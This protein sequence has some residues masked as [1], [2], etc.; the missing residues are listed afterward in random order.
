[1]NKTGLEQTNNDLGWNVGIL[2]R[3]PGKYM[4][5]YRIK[6][7]DGQEANGS[8]EKEVQENPPQTK[9]DSITGM[10][11]EKE[12]AN[13]TSAESNSLKK[14]SRKKECVSERKRLKSTSKKR[15]QQRRGISSSCTEIVRDHH[16][17]NKR[18]RADKL[19]FFTSL[20]PQEQKNHVVLRGVDTEEIK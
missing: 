11:I 2:S 20:L 16:I 18:L 14:T 8:S 13:E 4:K 1:M 10:G 5:R 17:L 7:Q 9:I 6:I 19:E 3:K 15:R 12:N